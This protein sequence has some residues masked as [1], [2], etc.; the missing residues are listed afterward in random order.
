MA[1]AT[2]S[3]GKFLI[4]G[5]PTQIVSGSIHYFRVHPEQ[6][7]HR[8]AAARAMGLNAIETYTCWNLHEPRPGQFDFTGGLDLGRFLDEIK[9]AG[10]FA[11]VRPGPYI[12]AEWDNGGL[13]PWLMTIPDIRFRCMNKP[14]LDAVTRYFDTLMPVI[15]RRIADGTVIAL[16]IENEYGSYGCDKEYI[17]YLRDLYRNRYQLDAL[18][19]TSDGPGDYYLQGGTIDGLFQTVNFGSRATEA[20]AKSRSYRPEGPDFCMEFWDGWFDHWGEKHHT[21]PAAEVAAEVETMLKSGAS[22]NFYMFH[23]GTNFGFTNGANGNYGSFEPTTTSYDYA[24]PLS[25]CGDI[26]PTYLACREV[27]AKYRGVELP[28]VPANPEKLAY[29]RVRLTA[30]APLYRVMD[31]IG[32]THKSVL[33][34][35]MEYYGQ[36][37]GFLNYRCHLTGPYNGVLKLLK[38]RDRAQLFLDGKPLGSFY[39]CDGEASLEI[40]VPPQGA[41]LDVL[42]ENL[43]RVN[44]GPKVA[45]EPKGVIGG[46]AING[47]QQRMGIEATTL[48]L[49]N[50]DL[51]EYGDFAETE[52]IPAFHRGFFDVDKVAD[53]FL[54]FPGVKGMAYING[55]NLGRYWNIGPGRTLYVPAPVLR[56]GRNEVVIFE[57]HKLN[58]PEVNFLDHHDLDWSPLP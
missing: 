18:Y 8:I 52:N 19:F 39:R 15:N 38:L 1:R 29:G 24:A 44:Y 16:Q 12:C 40:S 57:L 45:R 53:T 34:E 4:D 48:E 58:A 47:W 33:P 55:F 5:K 20:F 28:P 10:M 13:P 49:D 50:I 23:G 11:I 26:T 30:S 31:K 9:A 3:N 7:A 56:K 25:E 35:S 46:I 17:A 54:E 14:Y 21:R 51:I 22:L 43:G 42:V 27:I 2:I 6:W 36:Q 37:F 41:T 32:T